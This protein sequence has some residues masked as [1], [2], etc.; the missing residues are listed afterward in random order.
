MSD[1]T[2]VLVHGAFSESAIWAGVIP[3]LR[4]G[5]HRVTAAPNPLR[6]LSGDA[7]SISSLVGNA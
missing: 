7:T 6:S 1:V 5:G 2:I 3:A 4:T